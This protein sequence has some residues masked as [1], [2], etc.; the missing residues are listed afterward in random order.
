MT[1][2]AI[3]EQPFNH[4]GVGAGWTFE[5]HELRQAVA[6]EEPASLQVLH[7]PDGA[8]LCGFGLTADVPEGC[9]CTATL[10]QVV[11]KDGPKQRPEEIPLGTLDLVPG[12]ARQGRDVAH[13]VDFD[14]V[15]FIRLVGAA[16]GLRVTGVHLQF[17]THQKESLCSNFN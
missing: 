12:L 14:S 4:G 10:V 8:V 9:R 5:A 1:W 17:S 7:R 15:Y 16:P 6:T 13:V 11:L 3:I 2:P